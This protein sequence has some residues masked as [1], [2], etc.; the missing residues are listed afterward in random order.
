MS[1]QSHYPKSSGGNGGGRDGKVPRNISEN[2]SLTRRGKCE[3]EV[4]VKATYDFNCR[5]GS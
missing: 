5:R 4:L 3:K 1:V 2:P